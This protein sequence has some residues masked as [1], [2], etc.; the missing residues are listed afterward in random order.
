M[1]NVWC[2]QEGFL[3]RSIRFWIPAIIGALVMPAFYYLVILTAHGSGSHAGAGMG[4]MLLFYPVPLLIRITFAGSPSSDAF[5]SQ[6]I[7]ILAVGVG[8]VQFPLYGFVISYA[9]LKQ[10]VWLKVLAGV[11]WLHIV[12]IVVVLAIALIRWSL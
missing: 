4:L 10:S 11:I 3:M 12:V 1:L 5:V 7:S 8:L 2:K 9:K 6:I